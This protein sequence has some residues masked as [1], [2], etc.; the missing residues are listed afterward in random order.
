M[1]KQRRIGFCKLGQLMGTL[2]ELG[3]IENYMVEHFKNQ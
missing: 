3:D 1:V 2:E